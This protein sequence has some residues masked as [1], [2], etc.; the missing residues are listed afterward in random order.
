MVG[1]NDDNVEAAD[2]VVVAVDIAAMAAK[3]PAP[4][5][6]AALYMLLL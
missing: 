6:V 1:D 5:P 4:A 3:A 2:T